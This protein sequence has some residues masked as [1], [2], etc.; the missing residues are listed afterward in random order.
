MQPPRCRPL[1]TRRGAEADSGWSVVP[2]KEA[3]TSQDVV[4]SYSRIM[5]E[6]EVKRSYTPLSEIN[7]D[8]AG[9]T[10][11]LRTRVQNVRAK[12]R[13]NQDTS[14]LVYVSSSV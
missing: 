12:V 11:W 9:Q 6:E 4:G 5:S 13:T 2:Y 1:T 10:V 14:I 7:K 3:D 8:K